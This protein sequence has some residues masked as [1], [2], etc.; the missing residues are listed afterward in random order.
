MG[1]SRNSALLKKI[2]ARIRQLRE[3]RNITQEIFFNDT[4]INIGRVERAERDISM[5]TLGN[6]CKYLDISLKEF[7]RTF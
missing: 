5:S 3:E 6:I 4:G 7:F 2:G 1:K